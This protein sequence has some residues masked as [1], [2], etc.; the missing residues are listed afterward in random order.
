M[1]DAN[2]D[3]VFLSVYGMSCQGCIRKIREQIQAISPNAEVI[4]EPKANH[5]EVLSDLNLVQIQGAVEQAGFSISENEPKQEANT[6]SSS[7][8]AEL[9]K[10]SIER[11]TIQ[12]VDYQIAISGMTC[13]GCVNTVQSALAKVDGTKK[14]EVNF[15]SHLA[16]VSSSARYQDLLT[17][18]SDAGYQ[19]ELV[20]DAQ[21]NAEQKMAKDAK[22]YRHKITS[23]LMGLSLG[24]PLMLYSLLGGSMKVSSLIE[25]F[26]WFFIGSVCALIMY[27]A[28][29][30]YFISAWKAVRSHHANM[31][32]LI[33]IGTG[34]AWLYSMFVVLFPDFLPTN[35]RHLYFEAAVMIIGLINLGQALEVKARS[36]TNQALQ[37]LLDLAP[38]Q[39]ILVRGGQDVQ[40]P[41]AHVNV[42]DALRLRSGDAVPVDGK[43][44][45]GQSYLNEAMLTG[46]SVPVHKTIGDLVKAG[47]IN[48][49]GSLVIKVL[50]TG[51]QTQL[52]KIVDM[53]SRAQNSKPPISH[54]ADKVS[55]VF[56]PSVIIIAILTALAWFNFADA[57][58]YSY[59]LVT[60]V[61][62][63]IIACPC[64]LGLATPISTM[65]GVGKAAEVGGLIRNGEALQVASNID[66][67]VFDKTGTITQGKPCVT[68]VDY[69]NEQ[70]QYEFI[71][72]LVKSLESKVS[73]PLAH[74]LLEYID[75]QGSKQTTDKGSVDH[76]TLSEYENLPGLGVRGRYQNDWYYLGNEKL[77]NQ[78]GLS[79]LPSVNTEEAG[80]HVYLFSSDTLLSHYLLQDPIQESAA[81][82]LKNL[83]RMGVKLIMLTGDQKLNTSQVAA[84]LDLDE[85][86]AELLPEDKLEWIKSLQHQGNVVGMIGDGINDAPALAQ[87]DVGFAM[88]EGTDVAME[89][90][91][92]TLLHNN[93]N[94]LADVIS[95]SK[96]SIRNIKQNLWGAFAY[97]TLGIP[98]AA[99]LLYPITGWLLSPIIA[100]VA[101]SLSS[102]TVV[103][104]ANRL[105]QVVKK[106]LKGIEHAH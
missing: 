5:L 10:Q 8:H 12:A 74:A 16:Q 75:R 80:S 26:V 23:S 34:S 30:H 66:C 13:A 95:V 53:V 55:A 84:Q 65:I 68:K 97:N 35:I 83:K 50:K 2:N 27:F 105:R 58:D 18:I 99:G 46:E 44:V 63:L 4:G 96:A 7:D 101:M 51:K 56:V 3:K 94:A 91:D 11:E 100:G 48:T 20:T 31:D 69:F 89:S 87:A 22:E 59:M 57:D 17:A 103:L 64:A 49:N 15:A 79:V 62:V 33:A 67:L 39:A 85:Y 52:A 86:H 6:L 41:V 45:E 81:N 36:K 71:N 32:L 106:Q 73:H 88:G 37:K 90:A 76:I 102:V 92:V 98:I 70:A 77:L 42:G 9:E 38:K 60:A 19:G 40:V 61:S 21:Q 78:A 24:V 47:T 14:V 25:Q 93:L 54:L 82:A 1:T 28:G 72:S 104:N 43:V 29:R